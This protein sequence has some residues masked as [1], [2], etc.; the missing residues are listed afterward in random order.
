MGTKV[1]TVNQVTCV[2]GRLSAPHDDLGE[3]DDPSTICIRDK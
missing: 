1:E 3:Y 2:P